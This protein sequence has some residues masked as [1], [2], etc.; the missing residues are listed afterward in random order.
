MRH[1]LGD[2]AYS[3]RR[4]YATR[5]VGGAVSVSHFSEGLAIHGLLFSD[6]DGRT[7][8]VETAPVGAG[9]SVWAS[10][11]FEELVRGSNR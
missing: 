7:A 3:L 8:A 1:T 9:V 6:A 4:W 10:R 2:Q 11:L 5:E